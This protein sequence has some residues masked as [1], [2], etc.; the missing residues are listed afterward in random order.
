MRVITKTVY[1]FDELNEAAKQRA[2]ENQR[3]SFYY[4][5]S[6]ENIATLKA[7][8]EIFPIKII[9]W[10]YGDKNFVNFEMQCTYE[11]ERL[12]GVRLLSYITNNYYNSLWKGKYYSKGINL[13]RHSKIIMENSYTLTGYHMDNAILSPIY[14]FM[15]NPTDCT[16]FEDLMEE[17][18]YSWV[19]ACRDDTQQACSDEGIIE[20][21]KCNEYEFDEDGEQQ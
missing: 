6:D 18:L 20:S 3:K 11:I 16:D 17:C 21:I 10:E 4:F 7:F 14:D 2:I 19:Y 5:W 13:S 9:D 1:D 15:K 8:G 12:S